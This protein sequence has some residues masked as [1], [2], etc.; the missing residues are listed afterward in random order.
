[1]IT[2]STNTVLATFQLIFQLLSS[3]TL[4]GQ[5]NSNNSQSTQKWLDYIQLTARCLSVLNS[6]PTLQSPVTTGLLSSLP[7]LSTSYLTLFMSLSQHQASTGADLLRFTLSQL[8]IKSITFIIKNNLTISFNNQNLDT[9][10][11]DLS[12]EDKKL[13]SVQIQLNNLI[14]SVLFPLITRSIKSLQY[15]F[16]LQTVVRQLINTNNNNNNPLHINPF[17]SRLQQYTLLPSLNAPPQNGSLLWCIT[18]YTTAIIQLS[19]KL[20]LQLFSSPSLLP[21]L[22]IEWFDSWSQQWNIILSLLVDISIMTNSSTTSPTEQQQTTVIAAVNNAN[23]I[24]NQIILGFHRFISQHIKAFVNVTIS[25]NN[26]FSTNIP[27]ITD[28]TYVNSPNITLILQKANKSI[29][30]TETNKDNKFIYLSLLLSNLPLLSP[31]VKAEILSSVAIPPAIQ[32][33]LRDHLPQ[34]Q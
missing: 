10:Q 1:V 14:Q 34:Q 9:N 17:I 3:S 20:F 16:T 8:L 2:K 13:Q 22:S 28:H 19:T 21:S 15:I 26:M 29:L 18:Y 25:E 6:P 12:D 11:Q 27:Y 4:I 5:N 23:T 7:P 31:A 33:M 24:N 32:N 30:T